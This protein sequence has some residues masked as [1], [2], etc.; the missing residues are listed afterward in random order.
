MSNI[1]TPEIRYVELYGDAVTRE[2]NTYTIT[3]AEN[4]FSGEFYLRVYGVNLERI[5]RDRL[6]TYNLVIGGYYYSIIGYEENDD[7]S[8]SSTGTHSVHYY[9]ADNNPN[10]IY[11][12]INSGNTL[13][14]TG[15]VLVVQIV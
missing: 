4:Q 8:I 6:Y 7:G 12:T 1:L 11:Y 10:K 14:D 3:I 5:D 2:G 9:F 13:V 15:L